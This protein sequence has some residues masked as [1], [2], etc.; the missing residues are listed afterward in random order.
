MDLNA[1]ITPTGYVLAAAGVLVGTAVGS[2]LRPKIEEKIRAH[3]SYKEFRR[4]MQNPTIVENV[5]GSPIDEA[6]KRYRGE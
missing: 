2:Y 5:P 4:A 6:Q 1:K 3:R